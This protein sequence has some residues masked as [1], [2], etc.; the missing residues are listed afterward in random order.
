MYP[1]FTQHSKTSKERIA[2]LIRGFDADQMRFIKPSTYDQ[3]SKTVDTENP[4]DATKKSCRGIKRLYGF[5]YKWLQDP[6]C[7]SLKFE[8]IIGPKGGGSEK[9]QLQVIRE[10]MRF[11]G[12]PKGRLNPREVAAALYDEN[13]STFRKGQIDSWRNDFT[14]ELHELFMKESG[15]LLKQW[16]YLS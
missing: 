2:S 11:T 8:D 15:E 12:T 6:S 9:K 10:L 4:N 1:V 3:I 14:P 16:G 7:F 13:S 5:Y